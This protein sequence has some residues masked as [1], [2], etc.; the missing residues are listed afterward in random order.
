MLTI[1]KVEPG[2]TWAVRA[3]FSVPPPGPL[4]A[5][6][7]EPSLTRIATRAVRCGSAAR[8]ASAAFWVLTSRVVFS[9]VP[10]FGSLRKSSVPTGVVSPVPPCAF[11]LP[12][13]RVMTTLMPTVPRSCFSY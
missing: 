5:A 3:R 6:R 13:S 9:G 12:S 4:A 10:G 11:S 2:G 1:L 8:A 7:T